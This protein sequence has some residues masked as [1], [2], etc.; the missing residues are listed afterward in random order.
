MRVDLVGIRTTTLSILGISG[1]CSSRGWPACPPG[2]PRN[3]SAQRLV[4]R[5]KGETDEG[6]LPA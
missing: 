1:S 5:G 6:A 4:E 2:L 3:Q